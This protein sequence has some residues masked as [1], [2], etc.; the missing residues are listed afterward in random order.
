MKEKGASVLELVVV[1]GIFSILFG[2][3][4]INLLNTE[5]KTSIQTSLTTLV[6]DIK[7]QQIKAMSLEMGNEL[8]TK[9]QGLY[10]SQNSYTLFSG[11]EYFATDSDNFVIPLGNNVIFSSV[12]LPNRTLVFSKKSGEISGYD[13]NA[14]SITIQNTQSNETKTLQINKLGIIDTLQ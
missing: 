13:T 14:H 3:I 5:S 8:I 9:D 1:M 12:L 2:F 10:F 4:G 11:S 7:Q 6:T